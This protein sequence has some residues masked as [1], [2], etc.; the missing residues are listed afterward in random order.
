MNVEATSG[1]GAKLRSRRQQIKLNEHHLADR[2]G[3]NAETVREWE[4]SHDLPDLTLAQVSDIAKALDTNPATLVPGHRSDL[5]NG[6]KLQYAGDADAITGKRGGAEYYTY[7]CLVRTHTAP[8]MV[9]LLVDVLRQGEDE[10]QFN[11]GHPG[12]EFIY[13]LEGDVHMRWGDPEAPSKADLPQGSSIY[14]APFVPHA[15]VATTPAARLLA[16]NF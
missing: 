9:P 5:D 16:V 14:I 15:F 4:Q 6:V 2:L 12:G 11:A 7:H 1:F 10:S 3:I 8:N 13:V